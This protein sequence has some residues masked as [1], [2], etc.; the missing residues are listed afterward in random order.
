MEVECESCRSAAA[1][2]SRRVN[3]GRTCFWQL[4]P[5]VIQSA[6]KGAFRTLT[7]RYFHNLKKCGG[8][9]SPRLNNAIKTQ[10][11]NE[12]SSPFGCPG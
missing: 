1:A 9:L 3:I 2:A 7:A 6:I 8:K 11:V 10:V 4:N 12:T 5:S